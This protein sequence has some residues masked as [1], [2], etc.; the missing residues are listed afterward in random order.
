MKAT[1]VDGIYDCDPVTHADAVKYDTVTTKMFS[2]KSL[3]LW[4]LQQLRCA[5]TIRCQFLYLTCS[6][7]VFMKAQRRRSRVP[8]VAEED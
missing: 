2:P 5:K 6:L 7:K 1:K 8:I 4:T 3:R